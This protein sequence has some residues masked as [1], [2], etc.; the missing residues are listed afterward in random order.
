MGEL[1]G[2]GQTAGSTLSDDTRQ[3]QAQEC[4]LKGEE[5]PQASRL[6]VLNSPG[7]PVFP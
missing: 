4:P 5:Q 3:R 2:L 6:V 7:L 1:P